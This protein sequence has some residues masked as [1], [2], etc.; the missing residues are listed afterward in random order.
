MN[1]YRS[2]E[3]IVKMQDKPGLAAKIFAAVAATKVNVKA[4]AGYTMGSDALLMLV[5]DGN[6]KAKRVLL[7]AGFSCDDRDVVVVETRNKPGEMSVICQ[8]LADKKITIDF[9]Y[10]TTTGVRSATIVL[11]TSDNAKTRRLLANL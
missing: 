6:A 8:A 9:H 2:K 7:K 10:A 1:A 4:T 3:L 5:T 11:L